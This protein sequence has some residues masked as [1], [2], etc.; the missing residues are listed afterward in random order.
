LKIKALFEL[1]RKKAVTETYINQSLGLAMLF[2]VG[3]GV[4][5]GNIALYQD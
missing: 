3:R 5:I 4:Q 1:H 2:I